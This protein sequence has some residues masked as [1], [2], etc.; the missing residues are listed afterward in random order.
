MDWRSSCNGIVRSGRRC[1]ALSLHRR[2]LDLSSGGHYP[3]HL[4]VCGYPASFREPSDAD[5][6]PVVRGLR[7]LVRLILHAYLATGGLVAFTDAVESLH[8]NVSVNSA[9]GR[10]PRDSTDS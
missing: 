1:F 9:G 8:A 4:V 3:R 7:R 10:I 5:L 6:R 2:N